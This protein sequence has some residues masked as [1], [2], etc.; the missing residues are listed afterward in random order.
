MLQ[1]KSVMKQ[2]TEKQ[3]VTWQ[4]SASQFIVKQP[5]DPLFVLPIIQE[6]CPQSEQKCSLH[7]LQLGVLGIEK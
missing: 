6:N 1:P 7:C 4:K 3:S 5:N 2:H